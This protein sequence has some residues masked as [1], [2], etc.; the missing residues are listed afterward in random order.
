[1]HAEREVLQKQMKK[2]MGLLAEANNK[3]DD[4]RHKVETAQTAANKDLISQIQELK[5]KYNKVE[6]ALDSTHKQVVY[7]KIIL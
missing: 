1:M 2:Q 3:I 4:L 6:Q 7:H 5:E